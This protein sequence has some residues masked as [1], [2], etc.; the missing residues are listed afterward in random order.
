M[1]ISALK[2][3]IMQYRTYVTLNLFS[4]LKCIGS[5]PAFLNKN[6]CSKFLK[7]KFMLE[8]ANKEMRYVQILKLNGSN[9]FY[10]PCTM[11]CRN[12]ETESHEMRFRWLPFHAGEQQISEPPLLVHLSTLTPATVAR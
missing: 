1:C 5:A 7:N 4:F 12:R 6:M 8:Q 3:T 9:T 2:R 10:V 11:T